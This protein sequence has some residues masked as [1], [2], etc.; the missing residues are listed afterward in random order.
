MSLLEEHSRGLEHGLPVR[1]IDDIGVIH[2]SKSSYRDDASQ[3]TFVGLFS[4][5]TQRGLGPPQQRWVDP[6]GGSYSAT[7]TVAPATA[8]GHGSSSSR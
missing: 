2:P 1:A 7:T 3:N 4:E 5:N 6:S 8:P